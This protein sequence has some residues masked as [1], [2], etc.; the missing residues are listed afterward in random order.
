MKINQARSRAYLK[1][2]IQKVE[3]I[4]S[5]YPDGIQITFLEVEEKFFL[6]SRKGTRSAEKENPIIE[7]MGESHCFKSVTD[8]VRGGFFLQD[9]LKG[10]CLE[11]GI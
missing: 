4:G 3:L 6:L 2:L 7:N 1:V 9:S 10:M 8:P 11:H 5:F